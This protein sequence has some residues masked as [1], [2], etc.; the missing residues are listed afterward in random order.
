MC[1]GRLEQQWELLLYAAPP[2]TDI[3]SANL[4][5]HDGKLFSMVH[6]SDLVQRAARAPEHRTQI[7]NRFRGWPHLLLNGILQFA[8][9]RGIETLCF[10]TSELAMK[11][12]DPERTVEPELFERVY[13]RAVLQHFHATKAD[14]WWQLSVKDHA[15]SAVLGTKEKQ[16][17]DDE[18][19]FSLLHYIE[20]G[21]GHL[22]VDPDF[23]RL[24]DRE[25]P[26]H[27]EAML[28]IESTVNVRSTYAVVAS[29]LDEVRDRIERDGHEIALHSYDHSIDSNQLPRCRDVDFRIPGYSPPR[30][31]LTS[32]L[33]PDNLCFHNFEWL[34][35]SR[36]SLGLEHPEL[37][38]RL[39]KV[40][41]LTD[42]WPLYSKNI[43]YEEW[44]DS[45]FEEIGNRDFALIANHDC[46]GGMWMANYENFLKRL[47][48][49]GPLRTV[50]EVAH[51]VTLASAE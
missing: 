35:C 47:L 8:I 16:L 3:A 26:A 42:D 32:E 34:A 11:F 15:D 1:Q 36:H 13:D 6:L 30:A 4:C 37:S 38:E 23:A 19:T 50:E 21:L 43:P 40:P 18:R 17:L 48:S 9:E 33:T 7:Q 39:V 5:V 22:D 51:R 29:F 49:L 31:I 27:L 28:E 12:T 14:G 41:V 45:L 25:S 24:A 2:A 20:R 44:E 46:Y 10:C